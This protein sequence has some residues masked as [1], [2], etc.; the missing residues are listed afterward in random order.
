MAEPHAVTA[1][2]ERVAERL[3]W[4]QPP[5]GIFSP[6]PAPRGSWF[7][8]GTL[9]VAVNCVHRHLTERGETIAF[10]WE[11]EPED[12]RSITYRDLGGDVGRFAA[13][14]R[15]LGVHPGDRI[16]L[17]MG[18]LPET[19]VA[20]LAC[21]QIGA[22]Y[23]ILPAVLPAEALQER[24]ASMR[25]R[26]VVTQD[27][28][29]RHGV[30]LPLKSR[31]DEAVAGVS[32]VEHTI[33]IRRSGIDVAWFEGD[34]WYHELLAG[35]AN[36][37]DSAPAFPSEQ[38][39]CI[40]YLANRR[41]R[42]TGMVHG[43]ANFLAYL[44]AIHSTLVGGG[45]EVF[46]F[47]SEIGW[48]ATQG[49]GILASL[50]SGGTS[51][52]YEGMLDTP[53]HA[54]A[55]Q[56]AERYGVTVLAATPSLLR[57]LRSW[58]GPQIRAHDLLSL[59][60][61]VTAG[62]PMEQE[63]AGWL[64]RELAPRRT[65]ILDGWG[66]VELGG[67]V[68]FNSAQDAGADAPDPGL[69]V[70]DDA[71][72]PVPDGTAGEIALRGPWPGT[73]LGVVDDELAVMRAFTRFPGRYATGDRAI[74]RPDGR[75]GFLGRIDPVISVSG[76]LV[77]LTEVQEAMLEHPYVRR[78]IA[79]GATDAS[80]PAGV[81]A[82]VEP[83]PEANRERLATDLN[84]HIKS[85]LGGLSR[86]RTIVFADAL[87]DALSDDD[88]RRG[89]YTLVSS[90]PAAAVVEVSEADVVEVSRLGSDPQAP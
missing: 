16:G 15:G 38:P 37:E 87:A 57:S 33:V 72:Q 45:D 52:L 56:I 44:S 68:T 66:Q 20:M 55:W 23:S 26:V 6:D 71:G 79:S 36:V 18:L 81:I 47:P 60:R 29:W 67:I 73:V 25:A 82:L 24:L 17:H 3:T 1:A 11:G 43:S 27:G 40:V 13:A 10:H 34:R 4:A 12:R 61:I 49:H 28:A 41:E 70:V 42:P 54:R 64:E 78:A 62:E 5:A 50:M 21:A 69:D 7:P 74:R 84:E 48:L 63:L 14:L 89:A 46:W 76:Q 58:A 9:N 88:L 86:P 35:T 19:I 30:I 77:S 59:H 85:T 32:S 8:G 75:L 83:V 2:W 39:L 65:Q 80:A 53:S 22:V 90:R 51:V 31:A